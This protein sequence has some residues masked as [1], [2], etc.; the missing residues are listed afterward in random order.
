MF[1]MFGGGA[2]KEKKEEAADDADEPSG[3]SKKKKDDD[4]AVCAKAHT[5]QSQK[6]P[7]SP[8]TRGFTKRLSPNI[9]DRM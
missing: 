3:S 8:H 4:A 9:A 2:K 1:S 6:P 5:M 7:R